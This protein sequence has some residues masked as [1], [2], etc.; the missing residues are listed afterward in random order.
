[1]RALLD[2]AGLGDVSVFASGNLDEHRIEA[3]LAAGA[4]IGGFGVGTALDTSADVPSLDAVYKLQSYAGQPRRKRSE[5]KATWPGAKQVWREFDAA[6]SGADAAPGLMRRDH[7]SLAAEAP[8]RCAASPP[9]PLLQPVLRQGKRVA[10]LPGLAEI[11]AH[12]AEQLRVLPPALRSLEPSEPTELGEPLYPV[13][14]SAALRELAR[15]LDATPG[16]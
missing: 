16:H 8:P 4:P 3:L 2:A 6:A 15:R 10:D 5:G 14:V 13:E 11:R 1:V 9:R 7:L 12:H